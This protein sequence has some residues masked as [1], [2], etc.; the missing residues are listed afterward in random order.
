MKYYLAVAWRI[1]LALYIATSLYEGYLV[2]PGLGPHSVFSMIQRVLVF[3]LP[4]VVLYMVIRGD[5]RLLIP[6]AS[7][8]S[9]LILVGVTYVLD[10]PHTY[11]YFYYVWSQVGGYLLVLSFWYLSLYPHWLRWILTLAIP[12][13]FSATMLL[14][15]WEIQTAHH[16]SQSREN[17]LHPSHIP[18]AF[19]FDPNNLGA[20]LALMIP[21]IV[22]LGILWRRRWVYALSCGLAMVGLFVLYKTGSR[23]G[24]LALLFDLAALPFVLR[25]RAQKVA[26]GVL[27]ISVVMLA[28]AVV[29]LQAVP[30]GAH[31][32]F[33]LIKLKHMADLLDFQPHKVTLTK[34]PGSVTIRLALLQ[35]GLVA[36]S[37]HPLGLGP[38]GAERYF[39]YWVHHKSPYNTYG[40]IDAHNMWL[41][42]AIDFGWLGLALY[43]TFYFWI[44]IALFRVRHSDDPLVRFIATAGVPA[45]FGFIIGS[46]SPSSVMI[47][48]NV[49]WV[50]Y[51][52]GIA[53]IS[54]AQIRQKTQRIP[55]KTFQSS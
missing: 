19:Y 6:L 8:T 22:F 43:A 13:Y 35:S 44:L 15:L 55:Q 52:M 23:G 10:S 27:G 30:N 29:G 34:G 9:W 49:M 1:L 12:L 28:G 7:L 51:G 26:I 16:L 3:T 20:A 54:L 33:A 14:S 24:E 2:I 32:P 46:L 5:R 21:F 38:R 39:L 11:Y 50:V 53:A 36:L 45:L 18:T 41:E 4:F 48:F 42:N 31:L 47:G 25:G 17:G 37:H 40:V